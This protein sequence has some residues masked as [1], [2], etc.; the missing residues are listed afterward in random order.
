[1]RAAFDKIRKR[2]TAN[3]AQALKS[4]PAKNEVELVQQM[5]D[6]NICRSYSPTKYPGKVALLWA[7]V[8]IAGGIPA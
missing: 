6:R 8:E 5:I 7:A 4:Q 2:F 1:M 3:F